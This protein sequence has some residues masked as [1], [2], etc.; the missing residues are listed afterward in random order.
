LNKLFNVDGTLTIETVWC[1][2]RKI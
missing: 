1:F 2:N